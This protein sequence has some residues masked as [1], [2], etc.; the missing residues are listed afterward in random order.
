MHI[1]I[2]VGVLGINMSLFKAFLCPL[3]VCLFWAMVMCEKV[4]L[5]CYYI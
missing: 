2:V 5:Q 1:V 3:H 4:A